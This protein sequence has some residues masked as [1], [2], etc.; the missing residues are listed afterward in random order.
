[1]EHYS[2]GDTTWGP[3]DSC[4]LQAVVMGI[5]P[6]DWFALG[7]AAS[8]GKEKPKKLQVLPVIVSLVRYIGKQ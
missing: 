3:L 8:Y 2:A 7:Y 6:I 5:H 4:Y 1:V